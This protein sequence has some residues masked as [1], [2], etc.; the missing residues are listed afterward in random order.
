MRPIIAVPFASEVH[1][2][3]YY[4][5]VLEIFRRYIAKHGVDIYPSIIVDPEEA[6]KIGSKYSDSIPIAIL[7]TGGT[8]RAVERFVEGGGFERM[9]ILAHS[10][11]N[12]LASAISARNKAERR[13]SIVLVYSCSDLSS[14]E[15]SITVERLVNVAKAVASVVGS[16]VGIISDRDTKSDVEELFESKFESTVHIK[17]LESLYRDME[18]LPKN[19]VENAMKHLSEVLR[20]DLPREPLELVARLY[21]ALKNFAVKEHLDA[22]SIDCFPFIARYGVTPCIPLSLLNS[23]GIVSGCEADVPALLGLLIA[24]S[25]T[26][27]GGWI[28]NVVDVNNNRCVLAHCTIAL[29]LASN[30]KVLPHFE[31]GK[32]FA[33]AGE[34][35]ENSVTVLSIDRDL[36]WASIAVAKVVKSGN[37][38][39]P[40][41]RTQMILEFDYNADFIPNIAPNNH[42][43]VLPGN[44]RKELAEILY[45]LG[46]DVADYRE[47]AVI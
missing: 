1:G 13:G 11:H 16:R 44:Y 3:E 17:T 14:I 32:P 39:Y 33:L 28:A 27:R 6:E 36:S 37:L 2:R 12:S 31:T 35:I 9:L 40:A 23:E 43:I 26:R 22:I 4:A 34:L 41:C 20:A 38:G 42:H 30:I 47:F 18:G 21:L 19:D 8:S 46:L 15:C 24:K 10:E 7:L 45:I 29:N 5:G 25:V